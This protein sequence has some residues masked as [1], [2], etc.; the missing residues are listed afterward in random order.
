MIYKQ[1][2]RFYKKN[3]FSYKIQYFKSKLKINNLDD[4]IKFYRSTTFYSKKHEKQFSEYLKNKYTN[5]NFCFQKRFLPI[6]LNQMIIL[7]KS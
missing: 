1:I 3:N 5:K 7:K 4:V 2:E 6:N